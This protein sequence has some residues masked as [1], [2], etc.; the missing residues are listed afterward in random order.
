VIVRAALVDRS[1]IYVTFHYG[2]GHFTHRC[3]M[4]TPIIPLH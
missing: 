1:F 3:Y 2:I 4:I